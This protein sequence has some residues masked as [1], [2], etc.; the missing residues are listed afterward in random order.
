MGAIKDGLLR[1]SVKSVQS[2]AKKLPTFGL[3]LQSRPEVPWDS[4]RFPPLSS[5]GPNRV[6]KSLFLA[7]RVKEAAAKT[8]H[9]VLQDHECIAVIALPC[10]PRESVYQGSLLP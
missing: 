3:L 7:N 8:R 9:D 1:P 6:G 10:N 4:D 2:A 5:L